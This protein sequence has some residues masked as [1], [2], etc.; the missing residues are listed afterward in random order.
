MKI[1]LSIDFKEVFYDIQEKSHLTGRVVED[2]KAASVMQLDDEY[3][4]IVKRSVAQAMAAVQGM[5]G[6]YLDVS[7]KEVDNTIGAEIESLG[8]LTFKLNFPDNYNAAYAEVIAKG[9]HLFVVNS[10][11]GDWFAATNKTEAEMYYGLAK[12]NANEIVKALNAR[13]KP[14]RTN[15]L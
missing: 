9:V 1:D 15:R 11:L 13:C 12:V 14:R 2:Y 5:L 4:D 10:G 3:M 8:S 6:D 7:T